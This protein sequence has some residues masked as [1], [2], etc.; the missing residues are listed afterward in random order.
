MGS[1]G[2]APGRPLAELDFLNCAPAR[3][4]SR[5]GERTYVQESAA[6]TAI[7]HFDNYLQSMISFEGVYIHPTE[8]PLALTVKLMTVKLSVFMLS[9]AMFCRETIERYN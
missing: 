1:G 8:V 7:A 5:S 3:A 6:S 9:L 4:R 2:G